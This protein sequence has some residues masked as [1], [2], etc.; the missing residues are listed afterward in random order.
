MLILF[1][2]VFVR[3]RFSAVF[4][5]SIIGASTFTTPTVAA[6]LIWENDILY[7][8]DDVSID[9]KLYDVTF[10]DGAFKDVFPDW[11]SE[12]YAH[13]IEGFGLKATLGLKDQVFG[14][15]YAGHLADTN[16]NTTHGIGPNYPSGDIITPAR[17]DSNGYLSTY[18]LRIKSGN[19]SDTV[20][21][22]YRSLSFNTHP[23]RNFVW[24]V[25]T[26]A[27][28]LSPVPLPPSAILFGG[29]LL[30]LG[31]MRRRKK[32]IT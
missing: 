7:G 27:E 20:Y 11:N 21:H 23:S 28:E 9:S 15:A 14:G 4:V 29:A 26:P 24:A 5:A 6:T 25:W 2:A 30:G 10:Y 1:Y 32:V 19:K 22:G 8:A 12:F 13:Y 3:K 16:P 18:N 31:A 17:I